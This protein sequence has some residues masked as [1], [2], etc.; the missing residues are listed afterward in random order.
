MSY[1][2]PTGGGGGGPSAL[3][4]Q[5]AQLAVPQSLAAAPMAVEVSQ[6]L[7]DV[8]M[9]RAGDIVGI[10]IEFTGAVTAGTATATV[11]INGV[12]GTLAVAIGAGTSA[13][14]VQAA[15]I[16]S[17]VADDIIGVQLETDVSFLPDGTLDCRV[18]LEVLPS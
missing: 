13:S 16:D 1:F 2:P 17:Y 10:G 14:A 18:W 12:A 7:D 3:P 6:L 11:L 9:I 4:E 15:G 8:N 5:W